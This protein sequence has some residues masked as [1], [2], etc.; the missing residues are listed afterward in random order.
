M[1]LP[2]ALRHQTELAEAV[3]ATEAADVDASETRG[4][5]EQ[6]VTL[7]NRLRSGIKKL[8]AAMEFHAE[9]VHKHA[10]H[11]RDKVRPAMGELRKAVDDVEQRTPRDLWPFPTY[12]EML[13]IK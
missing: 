12:R 13:A 10:E 6:Y 8:E 11:V 2:A 7:V 9:D 1:G 4:Q 5:L 3:A